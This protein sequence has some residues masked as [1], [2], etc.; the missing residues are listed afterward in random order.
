MPH[1]YEEQNTKYIKHW[2]MIGIGIGTGIMIHRIN[3]KKLNDSFKLHKDRNLIIESFKLHQ[4]K[5]Y[6]LFNIIFEFVN[7][8]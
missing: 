8:F 3:V 5:K 7:R 6:E 2:A 1:L 4:D